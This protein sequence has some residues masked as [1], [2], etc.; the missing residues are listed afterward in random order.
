M[1]SIV[2]VHS[3]TFCH[4]YAVRRLAKSQLAYW[5]VIVLVFLNTICVTIEHY[6]QP[7]WLT[8]FLYYAEYVFLGLFMTEMLL[9]MYGLGFRL[10]FQSAFNIFDCV[11]SILSEKLDIVYHSLTTSFLLLF[12]L[13][14][15]ISTL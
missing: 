12:Y 7:V 1:I 10:Y 14:M 2:I 5:S 9:K 15:A 11:V 8:T 6:G 3:F 4:R 13:L